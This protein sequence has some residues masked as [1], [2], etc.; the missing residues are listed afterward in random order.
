MQGQAQSG[1]GFKS[2]LL[3]VLLPL[4]AGLALATQV[5]RP[6]I[7]LIYLNDSIYAYTAR[8]MIA[9]LDYARQHPEVRGVV[10]VMDSPGGTVVDTE[11]IYLE[12]A[13]LRQSKPV[14]TMAQGMIASGAFYLSVGTDY[15]V[16]GPS[17]IIGNVGVVS[18]LPPPPEVYEDLASTGPYKLFGSSRD[19]QLRSMEAIKQAFLQAVQLGRGERL[20][21][22]PQ[23]L[24]TGEIW[25]GTEALRMGL[26]DE[27]GSV[28]QSVEKA[29]DL[30]RVA[31]YRV[32][33]LRQLAE[34]P[35]SVTYFFFYE[36]PEGVLTAY[37]RRPGIY[38]LYVPPWE[39]G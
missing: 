12:L 39:G 27:V 32:V 33:D 13:R 5:P 2:V 37:P 15:V 16:A 30:A 31:H 1:S 28:S 10:L 20:Q 35:P 21:I 24:L 7:G 19:A 25:L 8:D 9:Q 17:A 18:Q 29:A 22:G 4:L 14:V 6:V 11:A 26:V 38:L 34:L 36:T 23:R 3:W